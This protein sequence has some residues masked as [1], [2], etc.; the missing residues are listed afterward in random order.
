MHCQDAACSRAAERGAVVRR[1]DGIVL[2]DPER[3]RNQRQIVEACP[4]GAIYW[5]EEE[6]TPQKCTFC[7][8]LLDDGWKEPRCV[9]VCPTGA[10]R[11]LRVEDSALQQLIEEEGLEL[12]E[13]G[14]GTTPQV[15][16][17]NLYRFRK[18]FVGGSV[19]TEKDGTADC[20]K[21]ARVVV[22]RFSDNA[23]HE[24]VT[25]EFGDFRIDSLD[26]ESGR[27]RLTVSHAESG[28]RTLEF[29]LRESLSVGTIIL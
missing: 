29:E 5:N 23:A 17:K 24:S 25:D 12:Y 14:H 18:C 8:H 19:A 6:Q 27:H 9:A 10:L 2:I 15:F 20:V 22:T 13:P 16:Y 28:E 4:Y 11:L 3:A 26:R 7:A 21:G 1:E